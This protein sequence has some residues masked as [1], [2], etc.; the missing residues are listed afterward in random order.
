MWKHDN[1]EKKSHAYDLIILELIMA[2]LYSDKVYFLIILQ[3]LY[4]EVQLGD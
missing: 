3:F 2:M 4:V 1:F